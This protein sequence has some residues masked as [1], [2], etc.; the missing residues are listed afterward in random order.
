MELLVA[1][2]YGTNDDIERIPLF[3]EQTRNVDYYRFDDSIKRSTN[4]LTSIYQK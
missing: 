4:I 1:V 2:A 3:H